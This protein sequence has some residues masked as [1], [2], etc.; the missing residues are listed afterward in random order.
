MALPRTVSTQTVVPLS[1]DWDVFVT[2]PGAFTCPSCLRDANL[3]SVPGSAPGTVVSALRAVGSK[4]LDRQSPDDFDVWY[5]RHFDGPQIG[6][7]DETRASLVFDGLATL[8]DVWLNGEPLLHSEN[9]F[10][11]HVVDVNGLLLPS[12]ELAIRFASLNRFLE[13]RRPR[14][15]WKTHLVD[16]Q[17]V[18]WARTSLVGRMSAWHYEPGTIHAVGPWKPISLVLD[19]VVRIEGSD[20]RVSLDGTTG[21]VQ[22][23]LRGASLDGRVR[24]A[25]LHVG[26]ESANLT[27]SQKADG[28]FSLSG[29]ARV[30]DASLWWPHTHGETQ[31]LYPVRIHLDTDAGPVEI[32]YGKTGFRAL[33]LDTENGDFAVSVNDTPVFWRGACWQGMD[34]ARLIGEARD[35]DRPLDLAREANM[36]MLRVPGTAFYETDAFYD[37]CAERGIAVWQDFAFAL[38]DY[39]AND[40]AFLQS[41]QVEA[42]QFLD[43][44][45]LNPAL[46]V[47][48]GNSECEAASAMHGLPREQWDN[49]LFTDV[50]PSAA[51][52]IRPDVLW[53]RSSQWGGALPFHVDKGTSHYY[54]VGAYLRPVDDARRSQVRFTTECLGFANIPSDQA[55]NAFLARGEWPGRHPSWKAGVPRSVS[56]GWDFDDVR[57]YYVKQMLD[58]DPLAALYSDSERYLMLGRIVNGELM[59]QTFAEWRRAESPCRG[60]L[61]WWFQD[62]WPGAGW[63]I[64]DDRGKPKSVFYY[65]KRSLAP[66]AVF[67]S[68]EGLNG[69]R[70]H[71]VNERSR[72][73]AGNLRLTLYRQGQVSQEKIVSVSVASRGVW[74]RGV[75]ELIGHFV[76]STYAYRFGPPVQNVTAA[77]LEETDAAKKNTNRAFFFPQGQKLP[78]PVDLGLEAQAELRAGGRYD[79]VVRADKFAHSVHIGA[80]GYH[81]SDDFFHIEPNRPVTITLSPMDKTPKS[82]NG[83]ISAANGKE[84]ARI[85][86]VPREEAADA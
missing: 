76:D 86:L 61:V 16:N 30:D 28:D 19:R 64:L 70:V 56:L 77:V 31:A 42:R 53:A 54:G 84:R 48:C 83:T 44:V 69:L 55:V 79:L 3:P 39:P 59:A 9:M 12:N 34:A 32:D 5:V 26:E 60:A 58:E 40:A 33:S 65:L 68:D 23:E 47:L 15:A 7:A 46:A 71:I 85:V 81:A 80:R 62:L 72:P 82:L 17:Q 36:N 13:A 14:P 67:F 2:D 20:F 8:A 45:Q 4:R 78:S 63:G 49:G 73:F 51:R 41:V 74:E 22:A 29:A 1:G 50:L 57:D 27:V 6:E 10:V 18:R 35:Y 52:E 75:D 24:N 21:V 11:R 66:L 37:G 38:M 43:R 25:A